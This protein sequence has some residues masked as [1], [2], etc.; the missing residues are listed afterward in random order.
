[1]AQ[2][3]NEQNLSHLN[4]LL[5]ELRSREP[6]LARDL[7]REVEA[8]AERRAFGLNFERHVPE[9]VELPGRKVRKGDKVRI[10]PTRGQA[11]TKADEKLWRVIAIDRSEAT[12]TVKP[13]L[14]KSPVSRETTYEE[15]TTRTATLV[16]LVVVAE[17]RDPIYPGLLSTG[18]VERGDDRPYHVVINAENFHALQTL[19]FT[20]RGNVDCIYI[21]PPYNTGAKDWK[22]N[23]DYIEAD[24]LY[25]HSK[26]LAMMERRLLL[27]KELLNPDDS[28][29]IVTIDEKEYL[30]LGLLLEQTYPE[31]SIQM[32]T[33]VI[34]PSGQ[35]RGNQMSRVEEYL[36][37]VYI[38]AA[39][40]GTERAELQPEIADRTSAPV[41]WEN[42]IRRGTDARR[43]DRENQFYPFFLEPQTG[44]IV[45][46][47]DALL[48]ASAPKES[49]E[50]P[51]G[52]EVV[53][54][55]RSDGSEGRWRIS[56]PAAREL[57]RRGLV[58][59]GRRNRHSGQR[60]M[61]Y[62][63]QSDLARLDS[64]EIRIAGHA[65]DGSAMLVRAIGEKR[66]GGVPKT[67]WS[68]ESH[69]AGNY[70]TALLRSFIPGRAFPF[71][72]SLYA[73]EDTLQLFV[74]SKKTATV[75]DF[76][77]GSGTT[78]H[79]VMRLNKQD[80]GHRRSIS[81]TNNEVAAAEQKALR[82]KGLRPGDPEWERRGIFEYITKPRIQAAITGKT[83][84]G[85]AITGEYKFTDEFPMS[86]GFEENA[87]FFALTY[88]APLRVASNREFAKIAPLLWIRAGSRGRRIDDISAGWDVV[89]FYGVLANL[90]HTHDF[91][92]AVAA[93]NAI[94][95][96]Y[97]VT[98]EERLFESVA[99]ELPSHVE[100]VRLY[101]SYLSNFEIESG[102]GS[103]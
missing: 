5:R 92:E 19:L 35:P 39:K 18:K 73:V 11:S 40:A 53:W 21:D 36:Y 12:A 87:E 37:I 67:V 47:G 95:I 38:G 20:H 43:V 77:S 55:I 50:C 62:V 32:V 3:I 98:D 101:E 48:P 44:R 33:S 68:K 89:D 46:I 61:N 85:Q 80:G 10:L 51:T 64:G 15:L 41:S 93:N 26:W 97:I 56:A 30:R 86:D 34:A 88:E 25:R 72:K 99:Q 65:D 91:L 8:L 2:C 69:N 6:A 81:I 59:A 71:P 31:A 103:L 7:E 29:L 60:A 24:D 4:D 49:V 90:D 79:A 84:D 42:L 94:A 83:P 75:V 96:A 13:L 14:T 52:L 63:L 66:F 78:A 76:F 100:V 27:A 28:V 57:L 74:G 17:F 23:N 22:Y 54:P 9:A 45:K 70:G 82:E 16:D 1:M 58:R 102:R